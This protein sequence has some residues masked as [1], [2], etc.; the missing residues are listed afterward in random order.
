M[1]RNVEI[2]ITKIQDRGYKFIEVLSRVSAIIMY[3]RGG[4]SR[5]E[6]TRPR[7]S[8]ERY[9]NPPTVAVAV[10]VAVALPLPRQ[11][12]AGLK[13]KRSKRSKMSK[14]SFGEGEGTSGSKTERAFTRTR[15]ATEQGR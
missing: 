10:A 14:M 3:K 8:E 12:S 6:E 7:F 15:Q 11:G 5:R 13:S 1:K 4:T 9:R 2:C